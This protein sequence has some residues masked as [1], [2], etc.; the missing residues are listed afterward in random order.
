M[1]LDPAVEWY[2]LDA[3][4]LVSNRPLA[5]GLYPFFIDTYPAGFFEYWA[6]RG[7]VSG[8][9]GWQGVM[10]N[11]INGTAPIFFLQVNGPDYMLVDGLQ[12]LASSGTLMD[13]LRING[14]YWPGAYTFVGDVADAGGFEDTVEV[15]ITF[16]D[17][18]VA[19][20]QAVTT[21]EDTPVLITLT[22]VDHLGTPLTYTVV[23]SP[24]HG[25]LSGTAP[26]LTYTPDL[27][28]HGTDSFTF[29]VSDGTLTS[30]AA[31]VSIT[32]TPV[33]DD[34]MAVD[35]TYTVAEDDTLTVAVPGVMANDV[36]V[37]GD[38]MTV[39]ILTDVAHGTLML[40]SNGSFVYTPD[41]ALQWGG[42]L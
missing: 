32:V 29:T 19:N 11:I 10:W 37:D 16:N 42:Y 35:D 38:V 17:L 15:G 2:Y 20:A 13:Y 9:T 30:L 28:F 40:Y 6:T 4:N 5:N 33:N 8:A 7:V 12:Y 1:V 31:T 36:D 14:S 22:G 27:N 24:D 41:A 21:A 25:D 18:P 3:A 26:A 23:D 39:S 34:P